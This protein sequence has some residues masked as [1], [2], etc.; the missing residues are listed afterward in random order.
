MATQPA[1]DPASI[2]I[3]NGRVYPADGSGRVHEAIAVRGNRI[4]AVGSR[5]A[6]EAL[7]GPGTEVLDAGGGAVIP[8]LIDSHVHLL[9]GAETLDQVSLRGVNDAAEAQRRIRDWRTAHPD[10]PWIR[11]QGFFTAFTR[12]DL[13]AATGDTPAHFLSG[14][15]HSCLVNSA[16]LRLAGITG[17]TPDPPGG[18]I[19]RDPVSGEPTGHLLET[20]QTLMYPVLPPLTQPEMQR[21]LALAT[22]EAHKAGVTTAVV[23]GGSEEIDAYERVAG[24]LRRA[25]RLAARARRCP[26]TIGD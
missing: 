13:D 17:A 10:R 23:V 25:R 12:Q 1:S 7:R 24:C 11:G 3:V 16:A 20:A 4:A 8:G 6:I 14:D 19:V 21:L 9:I 22:T 15:A 2:V 26:L 18:R 5:A